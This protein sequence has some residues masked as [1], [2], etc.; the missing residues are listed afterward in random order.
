MDGLIA[1][2]DFHLLSVD[3][4]ANSVHENV[5]DDQTLLKVQD[6]NQTSE[7]EKTITIV[8]LSDD[9]KPR[10]YD[11]KCARGKRGLPEWC[12]AEVDEA[13]DILC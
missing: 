3:L 4:F 13:V 11:S 12:L 9:S 8:S 1:R 5:W 2:L 6:D 10:D 7:L